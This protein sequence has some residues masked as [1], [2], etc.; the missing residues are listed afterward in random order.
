MFRNQINIRIFFIT[1]LILLASSAVTYL[2]I[3]YA[4]PVSYSTIITS[5]FGQ[6]EEQDRIDLPNDTE[7]NNR[8]TVS[9][10]ITNSDHPAIAPIVQ[11]GATSY[12]E[13]VVAALIDVLPS[14]IVSML[15]FSFLCALF[16]S[17]YITRLSAALSELQ[18]AHTALKQDMERERELELQRTA[19]F[20]AVSHE[21]KTPV[22]ILKGQLN[23]MIDGIGIYQNRDKYLSKALQVTCRMENL[24]QEI[25]MV[26]RMESNQMAPRFQSVELNTFIKQRVEEVDDLLVYKEISVSFFLSEPIYIMADPALLQKVL[27]NILSNAIFYAPEKASLSLSAAQTPQGTVIQVENSGSHI[28]EEALP[29]VF[30]AFYRADRSRSRCTGGSGL[31]LY[32]VQMILKLHHAWYGIEN[33]SSGV[34]FTIRFPQNPHMPN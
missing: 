19:F 8:R 17:R 28:P 5:Y 24:V 3:A 1:S 13:L 32:I 22:T 23:G 26:S 34:C 10:T 20:S 14:L 2:L 6:L 21:L 30:E 31:G 9:F 15:V 25:L 7:E 16:Y 11:L 27:N 4:T 33:T 29:H 18:T 12:Q